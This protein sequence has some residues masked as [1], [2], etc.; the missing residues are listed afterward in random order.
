MCHGNKHVLYYDGVLLFGR[1]T[2]H[3]L[4]MIMSL[5]CT[6][7]DIIGLSQDYK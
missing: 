7:N 4:I 5:H 3:Y 1:E 2:L 6:A